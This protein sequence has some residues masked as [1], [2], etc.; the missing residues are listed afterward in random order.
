[1]TPRIIAV[2]PLAD[3]ELSVTFDDGTRG[4]IPLRD[5]L[6]GPV[7]EP[8]R[9]PAVFQQVF[10]DEFGAIAWPNGADLAPDSICER[11]R[12]SSEVTGAS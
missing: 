12:T 11:L 3:F 1:M 10:V 5:Q 2:M 9:D 4:I 7:F 8:L 6:F